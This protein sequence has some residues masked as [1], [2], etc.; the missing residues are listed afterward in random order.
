MCAGRFSKRPALNRFGRCFGG[1]DLFDGDL[2]IAPMVNDGNLLNATNRA[3]W[4]AGFRGQILAA[5]VR[6]GVLFERNAG[7]PALLRA[8]MH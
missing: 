6:L 5:H 3:S 1:T 8:V 4:G 2:W 7:I